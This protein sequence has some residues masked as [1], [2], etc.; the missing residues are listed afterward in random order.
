M[1]KISMFFFVTVA[2]MSRFPVLGENVWTGNAGD[3]RWSKADNWQ[4]NSAPLPNP[5][6][7]LT[8]NG[9]VTNARNDFLSNAS[10]SNL[11]FAVGAAAFNV[12][13]NAFRLYGDLVNSASAQQKIS[14]DLQWAGSNRV[15]NTGSGG[16][17]LDGYFANSAATAA[18][19]K[20]GSGTLTLNGGGNFTA[21]N[22]VSKVDNG[23]LVIAADTV[24]NRLD[25][26]NGARLV[27]TNNATLSGFT[28][29]TYVFWQA[30]T[31]D[32][33]SGKI[34]VGST[35]AVAQEATRTC[36]VN[37]RGGVFV[38]NVGTRW[39]NNGNALLTL[40]GDG[41]FQWLSTYSMAEN[42]GTWI[43]MNG[44]SFKRGVNGSDD[45]DVGYVLSSGTKRKSANTITNRIDFNAGVFQAG[46][47]TY[48]TTLT[49]L[50]TDLYFNGG[51]VCAGKSTNSFFDVLSER[52]NS[53]IK[54]GGLIFDTQGYAVTINDALESGALPDGGLTKLGTGILTLS[55]NCTYTGATTVSNGLL[56]IKAPLASA[57]LNIAPFASAELA[58]N[59]FFSGSLSVDRGGVF[60]FTTNATSELTL[61]ELTLGSAQ[62]SGAVVFEISDNAHFDQIS[63][64]TPGGLDLSYGGEVLLYYPGSVTRFSENGTYAL[65]SY[66]GLLAGAADNLRVANP[67]PA[68][69]YAFTDVGGVISLTISDGQDAQWASAVDGNWSTAINWSGGVPNAVDVYALFLTNAASAV[70]VT[71]DEPITTGRLVF[72]NAVA[73][74]TVAGAQALTL[75]ANAQ[76]A[77]LLVQAGQHV[78]TAPLTLTGDTLAEPCAGSTLTLAGGVA[79]AGPLTV[80]GAGSVVLDGTN[81][82][83]SAIRNGT[84]MVRDGASLVGGVSF[85]SGVLEI[86]QNTA[87]DA[88][89]DIGARGAIVRPATNVTLT[90]VSATAGAGVLRKEGMG[91][92]LLATP[93]G[94][95]GGAL[96]SAGTLDF[97]NNVFGAAALQL[98]GGTVRYTGKGA[99]TLDAPVMVSTASV[100][101]TEEAVLTL[102]GPLTLSAAATLEVESTNEVALAG[103]ANVTANNSK[104]HLREGTLSLVSGADYALYGGAR[105]TVWIGGSANQQAEL[106]IQPGARLKVGG[107]YI[108][109]VS[110]AT[111]CACVIRQEGGRVDATHSESLFIRDH[112]LSDGT[113]LMNG[114][115]FVA[116]A[117]SWANLGSQGPG[118]LTI[119]G[120]VMTLGRLAM[121]YRDS[122]S[123]FAG[124][125]GQ[126]AINGGRLTVAGYCSWMSDTSRDR[127]NTVVLGNGVPGVGALDLVA[128]TRAVPYASGGGR[129]SLTFNGGVLKAIGLASYG[130][131][132]LT[133]YLYGIDSLTLRSGGAI[134]ETPGVDIA[135]PQPLRAAETHGG[136][137]KYGMAALTLPSSNNAW[138]GMTDIQEGMLRARLNQQLQHIY[139]E[140]LI[141]LWTFD[142]GTPADQSGNGYD[143]VQQNDTNVVTYIDGGFCGKAACF[144]GQSSLKMGYTPAFDIK[145]YSVSAW[146]KLANK[147]I[148]HQGIFSTRVLENEKNSV[149]S[150]DFKVN[151][152]GPYIS[153]LNPGAPGS[154]GAFI[155]E[156]M[157]GNL[158]T[159]V[160]YMLTFVVAPDRTD[161]YLN[162]AWKNSTNI[163]TSI[164]L[165]R[166]GQLLT[167][168]R[169]IAVDA[170]PNGEMMG[171]GGMIDDVAIFGR[172]LPA[173][174][175][176][177]MY[178]T[179]LP[180]PRIR[181][182]AATAYDLMGTTTIATSCAGCGTVSNGVL[183]VGERIEPESSAEVAALSVEN[184]TLNDTN[185]V[186]A[187]TVSGQ[188]NDL[189]HVSNILESSEIGTIDLGRTSEDPLA[190]PFRRTV[191][192]FGA[193]GP[194]GMQKL[195]QWKVKGDGIIAKQYVRKVIVDNVN[196]RVDVDIRYKG[197]L[198][199]LK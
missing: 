121:G 86:T 40:S 51:T 75:D 46:A 18:F 33:Y 137:V 138:C 43:T 102:K 48:T 103:S 127:Y 166:A 59:S 178:E 120:G 54:A 11:T 146:V 57:T 151:G 181:V 154:T 149:G 92:L 105:D 169:G 111:N 192:T 117:S 9:S 110:L 114:G 6:T 141:A 142:D 188:T 106:V 193:L 8:F 182:A 4:G 22:P 79:G 147:N 133:N 99:L 184:L 125:G 128:T 134:I 50:P 1:R 140:G 95:V 66:S 129:T 122:V 175:I 100:L 78:I 63:V 42:G 135:V 144:S 30:S 167:L 150:F 116:P 160:W 7:S 80:S 165:L 152:N 13:G 145:V 19:T 71:L 136:L 58:S 81:E 189:V 174:E 76:P 5:L 104:I 68:K 83:C 196:G 173:D 84:L 130:V 88:D 14:A 162:G 89:F 190:T 35:L 65:I 199:F 97:S 26:Q 16:L 56:C 94:N 29:A 126:L 61:S 87:V 163:V 23:T 186:Y 171:A 90:L 2:V 44:G 164:S 82:T 191:M 183:V 123:L 198:L 176:A 107:I 168:G 21:V 47:F 112:G 108:D 139:P 28:V 55:T 41:E 39:A 157:G 38:A 96:I 27:V 3:A 118:Y 60:S 172:A 101:R 180:R 159:G 195:S 62:G 177:A 31:I 187:C 15:I 32:L 67:D 158:A 73:P 77:A 12:S 179:M 197:T 37:V 64:A 124:P 69:Q 53:R 153:N 34:V 194:S 25:L 93:L 148:G 52:I 185:L 10:F 109:S 119:N 70:T 113:Y 156:S 85:D 131:S 17:V 36:A 49:N 155:Y 115:T 143:L 20:N 24:F 132:S 91:A 170:N 98:G 161:A 45:F 74:Y 72:S